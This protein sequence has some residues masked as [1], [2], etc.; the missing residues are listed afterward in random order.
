LDTWAQGEELGP[1]P[2][3]AWIDDP[4]EDLRVEQLPR[5]SES[6]PAGSSV[7]GSLSCGGDEK[8]TTTWGLHT[9]LTYGFAVGNTDLLCEVKTSHARSVIVRQLAFSSSS[10]TTQPSNVCD[11]AGWSAAKSAA[12]DA[13]LAS[14]GGC[15]WS[16]GEGT[17]TLSLDTEYLVDRYYVTGTITTFSAWL[18]YQWAGVCI[19]GP[20]SVVCVRGEREGWSAKSDRVFAPTAGNAQPKKVRFRRRVKCQAIADSDG[21]ESGVLGPWGEWAETPEF[22]LTFGSFAENPPTEAAGSS[23]ASARFAVEPYVVTGYGAVPMVA[24][25]D[26]GGYEDW[27]G[28]YTL[29]DAECESRPDRRVVVTAGGTVVYSEGARGIAGP[30]RDSGEYAA[31]S[32]AVRGSGVA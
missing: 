10:A 7:E 30:V 29:V 15:T 25:D 21:S 6:V 12:A 20:D 3:Y 26:A 28:A 9:R 8:T 5:A 14:V 23:G 22:D 31:G 11:A 18:H 4:G 1:T 13:A 27:L 17:Y 16:G 19:T 24:A 2:L 32:V